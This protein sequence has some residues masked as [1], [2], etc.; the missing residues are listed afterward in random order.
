MERPK[1][2]KDELQ[3]D[4]V[5]A[6]SIKEERSIL[7]CLDQEPLK[8]RVLVRLLI[9]TGV[10]RGE[11]CALQWKDI[12][13]QANTITF[14]DNL[15]YTPQKGVYL[16]TPKNRRERTIDIDPDIMNLIHALRAE[17]AQSAIS[18]F[19]FTQDGSP[20][21]IHPQSPTRYLTKFAKRYGITHLHPHKL[22]HSFASI[23]ITNACP[24]RWATVTR[25]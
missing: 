8:W 6:C 9:D 5:E 3:K 23:A 16:D 25:P 4:H 17:Q 12:D 10:R 20:G 15:C 22:R 2:R 18:P 7:E 24:R 11:C 21:P 1:P 13:F 14:C 19:V